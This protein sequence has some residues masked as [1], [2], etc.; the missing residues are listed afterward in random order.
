MCADSSESARPSSGELQRHEQDGEGQDK[1]EDAA[2]AGDLRQPPGPGERRHPA[3]IP[4]RCHG[5]RHQH[6]RLPAPM[7]AVM[8]AV[9]GPGKRC[10]EGRQQ[11]RQRKNR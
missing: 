4:D 7:K 2:A 9:M 6:A 8:N 3:A 5:K 10:Q 11:A 1:K